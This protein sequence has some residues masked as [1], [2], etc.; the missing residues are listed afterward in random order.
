VR[1]AIIVAMNDRSTPRT[2]HRPLVLRTLRPP[3]ARDAHAWRA[4]GSARVRAVL[5]GRRP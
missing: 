2:D 3:R 4:F 5:E 1:E